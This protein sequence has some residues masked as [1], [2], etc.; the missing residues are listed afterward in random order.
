MDLQQKSN[1]NERGMETK[2]HVFVFPPFSVYHHFFE[3]SAN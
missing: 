1:E 2:T 3:K